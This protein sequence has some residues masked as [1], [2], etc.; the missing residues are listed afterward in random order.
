MTQKNEEQGK[1]QKF[2]VFPRE[3]IAKIATVKGVRI[4]DT[5]LLQAIAEDLTYKLRKMVDKSKARTRLKRKLK[6]T[7]LLEPKRQK[8]KID[9]KFQNISATPIDLNFICFDRKPTSKL[10]QHRYSQKTESTGLIKKVFKDMPIRFENGISILDQKLQRACLK[11]LNSHKIKAIIYNIYN[12]EELDPV[13]VVHTVKIML[14]S[15]SQSYQTL[16]PFLQY[17]LVTDKLAKTTRQQL[18][19]LVLDFLETSKS[20]FLAYLSMTTT[21]SSFMKNFRRS[22]FV[23]LTK[24][25]GSEFREYCEIFEQIAFLLKNSFIKREEIERVLYNLH[26][27]LQKS[28]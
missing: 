11:N 7:T 6:I 17:L 12:A 18:E 1:D 28:K 5:R 9:D 13:F 16:I 15:H 23:T 2:T 20:M 25:S 26:S 8:I 4:N 3:T 27:E 14:S 19:H 24:I 22:I 10:I 21:L